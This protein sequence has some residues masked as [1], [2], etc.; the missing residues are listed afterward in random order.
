MSLIDRITNYIKIKSLALSLAYDNHFYGDDYYGKASNI[1]NIYYAAKEGEDISPA[2]SALLKVESSN[3]NVALAG[4]A[5]VHH[6][7]NTSDWD[8]LNKFLEN[9]RKNLLLGGMEVLG[10]DCENGL[11]VSN[12]IPIHI[13]KKLMNHEYVDIRKN[14]SKMVSAMK[15]PPFNELVELLDGHSE[16]KQ[17]ALYFIRELAEKGADISVFVPRLLGLLHEDKYDIRS[18]AV[19]SIGKTGNPEYIPQLMEL[20]KDHVHEVRY[21]AAEALIDI[22][23]KTCEKE[24]GSSALEKIKMIAS[25]IREMKGEKGLTPYERRFLLVSLASMTERIKE[26]MGRD[27]KFPVKGTSKSVYKSFSSKTVYTR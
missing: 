2:I 7:L 12:L 25:A 15:N 1:L 6:Y 3:P 27:K 20:L 22:A 9:S 26:T 11:D 19:I 13:I 14:S 4:K 16:S 18:N 5:I 10:E 8:A 23:K 21:S 17:I 24:Q